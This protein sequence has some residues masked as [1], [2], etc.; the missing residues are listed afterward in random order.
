MK[1]ILP[2]KFTP[3]FSEDKDHYYQKSGNA[4]KNLLE[5]LLNSSDSYCMYTYE[6]VIS[7]TGEFVGNLEH[8]IE[9]SEYNGNSINPFNCKFNLSV[10]T[11]IANNK[12]KKSMLKIDS[13]CNN[14][15]CDNKYSCKTA[16]IELVNLHV[17]AINNNNF[18]LMPNLFTNSLGLVECDLCYSLN[19]LKFQPSDGESDFGNILRNHINIFKLNDNMEVP[20]QIF[21]ICNMTIKNNGLP[22]SYTIPSSSNLIV[23]KF[24]SF[25]KDFDIKFQLSISRLIVKNY[26]VSFP[27]DTISYKDNVLINKQQICDIAPKHDGFIHN[28]NYCNAKIIIADIIN[29]SFNITS[30]QYYNNEYLIIRK[31]DNEFKYYLSSYLI[32]LNILQVIKG[33]INNFVNINFQEESWINFFKLT[34]NRLKEYFQFRMMYLNKIPIKCAELIYKDL[35]DL[36]IN[37][38]EIDISSLFTQYAFCSSWKW[39]LRYV[40]FKYDKNNLTWKYDPIRL[41]LMHSLGKYAIYIDNQWKRH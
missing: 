7:G 9:K 34:D 19:S 41:G 25:L 21:N 33:N 13:D 20:L 12:Y 17:E 31:Y 28:L 6:K 32:P 10:S 14:F 39:E 30:E 18:F 26:T 22:N 4:R 24:L 37:N 16:C 40:Y 23:H 27:T 3:K 8:S 11:N 35:L 5:S 36:E 29:N 38:L 1:I 2:L 15:N